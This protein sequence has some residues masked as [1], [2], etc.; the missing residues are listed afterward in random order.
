MSFV[1]PIVTTAIGGVAA[2]VL[3]RLSAKFVQR[4]V[5]HRDSRR[6]TGTLRVLRSTDRVAVPRTGAWSEAVATPGSY[7][8]RR[9]R[10]TSESGLS[11]AEYA[12]QGLRPPSNQ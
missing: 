10:Q 4:L 3:L 2:A 8:E 5:R 6:H 9:L 7:A 12:R 1:L 11:P